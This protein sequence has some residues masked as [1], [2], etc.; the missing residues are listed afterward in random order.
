MLVHCRVPVQEGDVVVIENTPA[1]AALY[2]SA[3]AFFTGSPVSAPVV[4]ENKSKH[5]EITVATGGMKRCIIF[6]FP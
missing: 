5:T 4:A 3:S 1:K 2:Q 6:T